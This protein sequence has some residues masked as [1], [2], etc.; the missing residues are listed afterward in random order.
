MLSCKEVTRLH[1][2]DELRRASLRQRIAVRIH[3]LMCDHC[4]RYVRELGL[5]GAAVRVHYRRLVPDREA[6]RQLEAD[7]RARLRDE[8]RRL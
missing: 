1:A 3:L 8:N 6:L 4:S 2:S 5:I 7:I